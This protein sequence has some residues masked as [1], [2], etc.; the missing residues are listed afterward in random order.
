MLTGNEIYLSPYTAK[1]QAQR[2]LAL[3]EKLL[4]PYP[5]SN[6]PVQRLSAIVAGKLTELDQTIALKRARKDEDALAILRTNKGKALTDE[7]N[8][9]FSGIIRQADDRLTAGVNE[10]RANAGW[11]RIASAIGTVVIIAVVG[12]A[13]W[14]L[15]RYTTELREARGRAQF[16]Q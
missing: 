14:T 10:Q 1:T 5:E 2:Q 3:L 13:A 11:L 8:V 9:F 4:A 7:A 12:G 16:A 6:V 15:Y